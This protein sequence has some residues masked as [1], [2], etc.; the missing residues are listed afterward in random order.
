MI[1][2]LLRVAATVL[3]TLLALP[4]VAQT[5]TQD[6]ASAALIARIVAAYGG[7]ATIERIAGVA[8]NGN[9][10]A[11]LR[12]GQGVYLRWTQ[13][14]R[15]LRV[16]TRFPQSAETRILAGEQV[17]RG[18]AQVLPAS[19]QARLAVIY[20]Y[21]QLDLPYGLL[22]QQY[23]VRHAGTET[24]DAQPTEVLEL[25]DAE[26]PPMRVHVDAASARIVRVAGRF[27][28]GAASTE[29]AIGFADFREVDGMPMPF[30]IRNY[31][32]GRQVSE[33]HI[34]S[35]RANPELPAGLFAPPAAAP[36]GQVGAPALTRP[37]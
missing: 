35:Y 33:M 28:H 26:G 16:E 1:A 27:S 25:E 11:P 36:P 8:A 34:D 3:A 24:V 18:G 13:R 30:L 29:L 37:S 19:G 4:A 9:I 17:W 2:S 15:Q 23:R 20:Q 14:P 10:V 21:K 12:G 31:A 32:G 5:P 6:E 7:A 22:T